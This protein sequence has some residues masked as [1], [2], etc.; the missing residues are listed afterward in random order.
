MFLNN[1][2]KKISRGDLTPDQKDDLYEKIEKSY[3]PLSMNE[4]NKI[5][6]HFFNNNLA[7]ILLILLIGL[8]YPAVIV[9]Y[10]KTLLS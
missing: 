6:S 2:Y 7:A 9:C 3:R 5:M 8:L 10:G 4:A 1:E